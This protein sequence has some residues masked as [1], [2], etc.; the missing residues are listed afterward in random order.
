MIH[1]YLTIFVQMNNKNFA[2]LLVCFI[3]S[4]APICLFGNSEGKKQI[5]FIVNPISHEIKGVDIQ[6]IIEKNLDLS[7]F[8]YK[9]IY[10]QYSQHATRLAQEALLDS[11][12]IIAAVGGDGTVNEVGKALIDTKAVLAIIPVGSGNG[13]ARHLGIPVGLTQ[14]IKALNNA[15]PIVIDT[16]KINDQ[17][18]LGFAGIGFDA[19]IAHQFAQF[20]K[21]GFFSYCQVV[22]KEFSKYE[23]KSYL[24][25]IDGK[26]IVREAF[27]ITFANSSQYGN[28]FIIAPKA[29]MSDGF[30]DLAIID[31][32]PVYSIPQFLYQFKHG[33]LDHSHYFETYLFKEIVIHH[34]YI[35]AHIDGEPMLFQNH[36][37]VS[38]QPKSL[39]ILVPRESIKNLKNQS[40]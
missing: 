22:L 14:A 2:L 28:D 30:L 23:P 4:F 11:V 25:T 9:I 38:I 15:H 1:N 33:T 6:E 21:R 20:G 7:R 8:E 35:Q 40:L 26:Q 32:I 36:I 27:I 5:V 37:K 29:N 16:G 17:T 3:I 19:H 31:N 12:D 10:T 18:F 39:K 34:P 13:L 24:M